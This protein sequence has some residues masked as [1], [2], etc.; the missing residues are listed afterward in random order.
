MK[1]LIGIFKGAGEQT[2]RRAQN[3]QKRKKASRA[4][5]K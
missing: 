5:V 4:D 2:K 1:Q 3:V